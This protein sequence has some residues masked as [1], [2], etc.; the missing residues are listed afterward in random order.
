MYKIITKYDNHF[1]MSKRLQRNE[2]SNYRL[3]L[4]LIG[5]EPASDNTKVSIYHLFVVVNVK[6]QISLSNFQQFRLIS[7]YNYQCYLPL[8]LFDSF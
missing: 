4:P 6:L 8:I 3:Y 5:N 7:E 2:F 1:I